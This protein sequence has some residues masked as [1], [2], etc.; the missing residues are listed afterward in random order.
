MFTFKNQKMQK[1]NFIVHGMLAMLLS[2]ITLG[3]QASAQL[4]INEFMASNI[5]ALPGPQGDYPDWIEIY[6]AGTE[7]VMLGGFF[8]CDTL[9]VSQAYQ[10]SN[11]YPDSVTVEAGGFIVFYANSDEDISVLN[12]NFKLSAG[13]EQIGFWNADEILLDGITYGEQAEDVSYGR[14]PDGG[15]WFFMTDYSPGQT[16]TNPTPGGLHLYINEFMASNITAFP[17]PQGDYPDWIEI[18]N[19]GDEDVM[20]GGFLLLDTLDVSQAYQIPATYPDSVTVEAGGFI[21]FYANDDEGLSVLNLDFKL[22]GSGEQ[23]GLWDPTENLLDGF[24]YEEQAVDTSYG[25]YA[26]GTD[27]WFFMPD[28]TPGTAN[29]HASSVDEIEGQEIISLIFP[30]PFKTASNIQFTLDNPERVE[31]D[32]YDGKGM[33][34][35]NI[36]SSKYSS[37]THLVKLDALDLPSGYYYYTFRTGSNLHTRK[38][39]IVR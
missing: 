11:S 13:S 17:G 35:R 6:N 34:L 12:L 8:F 5:D 22:S 38:F 20:L 31:I 24:T 32:L 28:F 10:I 29:Q 3:N 7:D 18:Y 26:D 1:S 16:N 37:G 14:Y 33:L 39:A 21:V 15:N 4:Y 19:A 9:D 23:I 2:I 25:R 30:N 27:N 36:T